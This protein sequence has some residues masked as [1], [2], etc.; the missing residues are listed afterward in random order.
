M[1]W[2]GVFWLEMVLGAEEEE[3]VVWRVLGCGVFCSA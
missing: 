3:V 1:G 2:V